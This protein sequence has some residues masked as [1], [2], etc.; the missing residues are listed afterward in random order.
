MV[1]ADYFGFLAGVSDKQPMKFGVKG[2][3][4]CGRC[5]EW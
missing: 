3:K 4:V 2:K 1:T 5:L